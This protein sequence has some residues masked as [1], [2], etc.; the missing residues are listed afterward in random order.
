M[1]LLIAF[2]GGFVAALLGSMAGGGAGF[3]GLYALLFLGLPLNTAIATNQLGSL[4]YL[5]T[6]IR[7]FTRAGLV[8]KKILL[9]LLVLQ[10]I[11]VALGTFLLI[12]LNILAIKVIVTL[13]I[14]PAFFLLAFQKDVSR[15]GKASSF[16][17]PVYLLSSFYSGLIGNGSGAVRT[18]CLIRLRKI[19]ALEALANG[20]TA[21]FPFAILSVGVLLY[22]G[23]IDIKLGAALLAGNLLGAHFGSRIAIKRGDEFVRQMLLILMVITLI[24]IWIS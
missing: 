16:W 6:S 17:K 3:F 12:Q 20:F 2:G 24:V 23:L 21:T 15:A 9:P 5:M 8:R 19:P 11:G 1:D 13:V 7:N 22:A 14:V 4:G 18:F 10:G